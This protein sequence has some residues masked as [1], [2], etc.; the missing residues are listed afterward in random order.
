MVPLIILITLVQASTTQ[1]QN[2][3]HTVAVG[4]PLAD[5]TVHA[6]HYAAVPAA[7]GY[8]MEAFA[9]RY[10]DIDRN[11][12]YR[13]LEMA[14][15]VGAEVPWMVLSHE[16]G[17]YRAAT[18]H[19]WDA[20]IEMT[21]WA[22]GLTRIRLSSDIHTIN[23]QLVEITAAG[24]NQETINSLHIYRNWVINGSVRYQEALSFLLAE[25]NMALYAISTF[26]KGNNISEPDDINIYIQLLNAKNQDI[27][28]SDLMEAALIA[29]LFSASFWAALIGNIQFV[30]TGDRHISIPSFNI[31]LVEII[32]PNFHLFLDSKGPFF[33]GTIV[34]NPK[35]FIPIELR[36]DIRFNGQTVATSLRL[37]KIIIL[38]WL[39]VSPHLAG[40]Y[41]INQGIGYIIGADIGI[42]FNRDLGVIVGATYIHDFAFNEV[43]GRNNGIT[44]NAGIELPF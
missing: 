36:T 22:S 34:I 15:M 11:L 9:Q 31:G 23:Q 1:E 10:P 42:N 6:S 26:Q 8:A 20:E 41:D 13:F 19:G 28:I 39:C 2:I 17:H 30:V 43:R 24:I 38:D 40:S 37:H 32:L 35:N 27:K 29:N 44:I 33:G 5:A 14:V 21:G 12:A 25:T 4:N 7:M 3:T 16:G 18:R